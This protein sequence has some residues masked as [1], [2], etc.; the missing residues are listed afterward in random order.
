MSSQGQILELYQEYP[1][2]GEAAAIEAS[3]QITRPMLT[4]TYPEGN[5]PAKRDQHTKDHGCVRGEFTVEPNLPEEARFG[6]FKDPR[7]YPVWIRFSNGFQS[8]Q[9]DSVQDVRGLAIKLMGVE[10][11]KVLPEEK[12]EKT[13]DFLLIN[14]PVFFI[15]NAIDYLDFFQKRAGKKT[16]QF[17]FTGFNPFKW[18][19]PELIVAKWS[20]K[21]RVNNLLSI[22]Y[23]SNS[24]Y[25]LGP[26]AVRYSLIPTSP[27]WDK[28]PD[29]NSDQYLRE[30]P[31]K[32]FQET[33]ARFDFL[34]QFQ[35]NPY[36]M[37]IEDGTID[38]D[39]RRSPFQKVATLTIKRQTFNSPAQQEF[40]ENL[41]F[42]PWHC[43]PERQP[44][45]G[46]NRVRR[47]VYQAISKLRHEMNQ[48]PRSEPTGDEVF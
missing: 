48:A 3:E 22:R 17:L 6:V 36:K 47:Q 30:G 2:L 38:G 35:T 28:Q 33:E 15:R 8:S 44:L 29:F 32:Y 23:W 9:R 45:G 43:L 40:C 26:R 25:K 1:P 24:P 34:I 7:T 14:Y 37:P 16:K 20:V 27:P 4:Q 39:E 13:Q 31:I 19:L 18:R 46:I 11:E 5:R 10:G 21:E 42:S 41:S 12:F